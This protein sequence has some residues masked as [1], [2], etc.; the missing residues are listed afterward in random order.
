MSRS[1]QSSGRAISQRSW[2][3][4]G[5]GP[6][7]GGASGLD[8]FSQSPAILVLVPM[9]APSGN[10]GTQEKSQVLPSPVWTAQPILPDV[11]ARGPWPAWEGGCGK[12]GLGSLLITGGRAG[13]SF[14]GGWAVALWNTGP[15]GC[16]TGLAVDS[17]IS[18]GA[19]WYS[20]VY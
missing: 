9:M 7:A 16:R 20:P 14:S 10:M 17:P 18:S 15:K 4:A 12:P 3:V 8:W 6:P 1:P 11:V 5:P 2:L 19:S 13:A